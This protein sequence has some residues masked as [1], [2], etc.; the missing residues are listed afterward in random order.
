[1]TAGTA[2]TKGPENNDPDFKVDLVINDEAEVYVF[3]NKPFT[4]DIS[5][6][7]FDLETGQNM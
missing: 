6:L 5:W 2:P 4:K 7:E 1:M 3:H